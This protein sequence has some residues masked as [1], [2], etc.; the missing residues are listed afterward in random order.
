[1]PAAPLT[2]W[3]CI[4]SDSTQ[5]PE[6]PP[7]HHE[8]SEDRLWLAADKRDRLGAVGLEGQD[9]HQGKTRDPRCP[10]S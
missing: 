10:T 5:R 3:P 7:S 8:I 2:L 4:F 6:A 1:M 9:H